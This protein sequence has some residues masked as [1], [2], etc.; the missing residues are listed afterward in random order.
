MRSERPGAHK[1]KQ[2][3]PPH[4]AR[5]KER[6]HY[7]TDDDDA[8]AANVQQAQCDAHERTIIA[9]REGR[10]Q[11]GKRK[12]MHER[13][14]SEASY[15]GREGLLRTVRAKEQKEKKKKGSGS[16]DSSGDLKSEPGG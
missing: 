8:A 10:R 13:C 2:R 3:R 15:A 4:I 6:L 5:E 9:A 12:K 14:A 11:P 1:E 7:T 16:R